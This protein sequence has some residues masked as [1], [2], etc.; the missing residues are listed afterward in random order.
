MFEELIMQPLSVFYE[1]GAYDEIP[2]CAMR[3]W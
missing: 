2:Y 3:K 1:E